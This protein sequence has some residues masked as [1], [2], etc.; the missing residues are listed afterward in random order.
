M[1]LFESALSAHYGKNYENGYYGT[2]FVEVDYFAF[3]ITNSDDH[4]IVVADRFS[5]RSET[6][7]MV[8]TGI[9]INLFHNPIVSLYNDG[10]RAQDPKSKFVNWFTIIEEFLEKNKA[11]ASK[12]QL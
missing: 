2:P 7:L 6:P 8:D 11:W 3:Q 5:M 4:R 10:L 9:F 1:A 12:F